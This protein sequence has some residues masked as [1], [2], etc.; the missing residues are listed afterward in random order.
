MDRELAGLAEHL[1]IDLPPVDPDVSTSPETILYNIADGDLV[2]AEQIRVMPRSIVYRW[3]VG[4]V[5]VQQRD[6]SKREQ[7]QQEDEAAHLG[8]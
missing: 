4:A 1:G 2:K 3:I 7:E 8:E 5:S 6:K